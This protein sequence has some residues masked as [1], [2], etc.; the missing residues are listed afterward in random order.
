SEGCND[1]VNKFVWSALGWDPEA[2][3]VETLRQYGRYFIGDRFADDFAQGLLALERNWRGPLL[4]NAGVE[5][6]LRQFQDMERAAGPRELANWRFQQA[7]YRAYYDAYT[8][9]RLAY[10]T[11]LEARAWEVLR[12]ARDVGALRAIDRAI[13]I[14]DRADTERV[15]A[16]R[17]ARVF[18]LAEA[19]YQS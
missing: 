5:T 3:A 12:R 10:E 15:S 17:R 8:R 2:D 9:D 16:D 11:E 6:T 4:T 19:L 18:E 7:L 14:L 13:A 1:D